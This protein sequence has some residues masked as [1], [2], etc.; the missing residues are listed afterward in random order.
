MNLKPSLIFM[1]RTEEPKHGAHEGSSTTEV[2][3]IRL[4]SK[5]LLGTSPHDFY[6]R[7]P[8]TIKERKVSCKILKQLTAVINSVPY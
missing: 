5:Y 6:A 4:N 2:Q 3:N 7:T 1:S 8:I